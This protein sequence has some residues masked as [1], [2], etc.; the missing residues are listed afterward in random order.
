[1]FD[2]RPFKDLIEMRETMIQRHNEIVNPNDTVYHLG[3]F[4]FNHD[5]EKVQE[6]IRRLNGNNIFIK[7]SHDYWLPEGHPVRLEFKYTNIRW[8][9]GQEAIMALF[10]FMAIRTDAQSLPET[11]SKSFVA[12]IIMR[13]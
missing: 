2:D 1:M 10:N 4:N 13:L 12:I 3:D 6:I 7:G 8:P 5:P 11:K 9:V